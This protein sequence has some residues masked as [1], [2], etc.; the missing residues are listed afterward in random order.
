MNCLARVKV[1]RAELLWELKIVSNILFTKLFKSLWDTILIGK[2]KLFLNMQ[3]TKTHVAVGGYQQPLLS[4]SGF[5][6][7]SL[8]IWIMRS[9]CLF[10]KLCFYRATLFLKSISAELNIRRW[11][12][13]RGA[14][15]SMCVWRV[16][17]SEP[18]KNTRRQTPER[19]N[20]CF[21]S[22]LLVLEK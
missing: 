15:H 20:V 21:I 2:S 11:N 12:D 7:S 6:L 14:G 10:E 17:S 16:Q 8:N 5:G 1:N 3:N 19:G 22:R 13:I 18:V 9:L 4:K